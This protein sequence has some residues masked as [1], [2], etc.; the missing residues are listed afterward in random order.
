VSAR[1]WDSLH[2]AT[3]ASVELQGRELQH[4]IATYWKCGCTGDSNGT[5]VNL[6]SYHEGYD[7]GAEAISQ[8]SKDQ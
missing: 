5:L 6:C 7:D 2:P 1:S 3:R 8:P 4:L